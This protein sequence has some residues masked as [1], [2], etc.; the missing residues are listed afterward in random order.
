MKRAARSTYVFGVAMRDAATVG[1]F[2]LSGPA[3]RASRVEAVDE[4]RTIAM[5]RGRFSDEFAGYGVHI[6]R[7]VHPR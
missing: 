5:S 7:I 6:Y 4:D 2:A 1:H 3:A